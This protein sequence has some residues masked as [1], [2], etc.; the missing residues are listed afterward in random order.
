MTERRAETAERDAVDRFTTI[1]LA[2]R[3]GASVAGRISG[4]TR[5]GLFVT[6]DESGADGLVPAGLLPW[7]RYIHDE[8][9]HR[10]VGAATGLA[11]TLGDRVTVEL[12]EADRTTCSLVFTMVE[13]SEEHTSELQSLMRISY[14][15]FCLK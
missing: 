4:V 1:F 5:F 13:R 9:H 2:D 8:L 12:K 11:F 10:L 6:L 14:A 7:D 15:V 3:V